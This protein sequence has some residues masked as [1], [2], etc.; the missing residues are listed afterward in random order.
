VGVVIPAHNEQTL[1][2][3]CLAAIRRAADRSQVEVLVVVVADACTDDTATIAERWGVRTVH[4]NDGCVGAA[5]A[6]VRSSG[7][8]ARA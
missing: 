7:R 1:L 3:D 2:P 5:R 4:S 8:C 6:A